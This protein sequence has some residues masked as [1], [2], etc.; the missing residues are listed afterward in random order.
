MS[1]AR[2][3]RRRKTFPT[4]TEAKAWRSHLLAAKTRSRQRAPSSITVRDAAAEYLEGMRDG[5]IT[6]RS[7]QPYKPSTIRGYDQSLE[8]HALP[9]LGGRR[10][11]DVTTGDVQ[12]LVE[13][14]RRDG[15]AGTT[16]ANV[17]N[18]LRA[19]YRRLVVLGR[20]S[21]NPT[22]GA[23]LPTNRS[24]RLHAGDPGDAARVMAAVA[25][26]D[27]CA[28][29]L[30][31]YAGLRLGELRALRWGDV[32]DEA[33][34]I[35]VRRS[36]DVKEGEIRPK[37]TA[38]VRDVPIL[39]PL[40]PHLAA[41]RAACFWSDDPEALVLGSSRRSPLGYN[42]LR[43]R[44]DVGLAAAGIKRVTLHEARHS[45]ASFLAASGIGIKDL[46]VILGHS[47]VTVSLDRYGHL[48]E[49][50]KAQTAA[51]INAW[52]AS[53]DTASRVAQLETER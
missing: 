2:G 11:A 31:F 49:A 25:E 32:D 26:Q 41:Q 6:T 29:A 7:G 28:W 1:F 43:G 39:A 42:G 27:R 34:V 15:H 13:G 24:K 4:L 22:R 30:A 37:S 53:A 5:S 10:V 48:F 9:D 12:R 23:V 40:L 44:T 8:L 38:G 47:S 46:T 3:E 33:G 45:F 18:P 20:V 21:D 52:F 19:I 36:W 16:I 51:Q 50:G 17:V 35:H 14:L